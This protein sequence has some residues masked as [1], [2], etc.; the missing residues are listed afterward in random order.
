M[1]K[2][3]K[4]RKV[5]NPGDNTAKDTTWQNEHFLNYNHENQIFKNLNTPA[6]YQKVP[7]FEVESSKYPL[8]IMRLS[9]YSKSKVNKFVDKVSYEITNSKKGR[10][11]FTQKKHSDAFPT[12]IQTLVLAK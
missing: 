7:S 3:K 10:H 5:C 12:N 6:G 2:S 9:H 1:L 11:W 4:R 8:N